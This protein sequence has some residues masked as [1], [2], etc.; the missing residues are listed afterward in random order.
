MASG[1][2]AASRSLSQADLEATFRLAYENGV[3]TYT[4]ANGD[5]AIDMMLAAHDAAGAPKGPA[6]RRDPLAVRAARA[7]QLVRADRRG[8]VV[9]RE[10]RVLLGRRAREQPRRRARRVPLAAR[11]GRRARPA[12]HV[13]QRLRRDA[14]RPDVHRLGGHRAH[15]ALG[16]RDRPRRA[17]LGGAGAARAHD[18]RRL[19]VLRGGHARARSRRARWP[20]S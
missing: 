19:S 6:A 12:L 17:H 11:L 1:A 20:T 9:L 10:P 16:R 8:A 18:R 3:Q 5:A 4:H 14:A 7:A 15:L 2:G 13:A